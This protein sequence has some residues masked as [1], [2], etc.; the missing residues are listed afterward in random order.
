MPDPKDF[1][2]AFGLTKGSTINNYRLIEVSATHHQ[3]IRYREYEYDIHLVYQG[4]GDYDLFGREFDSI[5]DRDEVVNSHYGNPYRCWVEI[6]DEQ[7]TG[8]RIEIHL[9]GHST[10][11]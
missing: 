3:I 6:T 5:L 9:T 4:N 10:R 1:L 8:D 11:V 7:K 2:R